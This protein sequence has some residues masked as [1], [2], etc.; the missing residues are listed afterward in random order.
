[1][2]VSQI[3]TSEVKT[4]R[5]R[6]FLAKA[7]QIMWDNDCGCVPVVDEQRKPIGMITDR[8]IAMATYTQGLPLHSIRIESAMAETVVTCSSED[9][10][11]TVEGLMCQNQVRRLPV[12]DERG[13]LIGIVSLNDLALEANRQRKQIAGEMTSSEI[14]QTLTAVSRPRGHL[15]THVAFAPE[16]GEL[17]FVPAPPP[18]R[19]HWRR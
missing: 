17:N 4:C 7:A 19:G 8:D 3:M 11:R 12:V 16:A 5:E 10:L 14:S 18:K 1:M 6:D 2:K 9:D 15:L 13:K